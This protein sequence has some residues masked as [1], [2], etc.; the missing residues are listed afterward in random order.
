MNHT[1]DST[2][3]VTRIVVTGLSVANSEENAFTT[4]EVI[5]V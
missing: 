1:P 5:A 2:D 3:P 4:A